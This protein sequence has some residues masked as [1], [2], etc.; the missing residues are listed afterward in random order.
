MKKLVL[1]LAMT[2]IPAVAVATSTSP[3]APSYKA[4]YCYPTGTYWARQI[5]KFPAYYAANGATFA[6]KYGAGTRYC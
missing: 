6:A 4:T 3:L 5:A 1:A 2:A